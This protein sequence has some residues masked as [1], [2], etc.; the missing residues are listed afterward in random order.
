MLKK[1]I[2]ILIIAV[3]TTACG[4][5]ENFRAY[6][7]T[8][9]NAKERFRAGLNKVEKQPRTIDIN[10][11]VAVH[12]AP[13]PAG[14]DDFSDAINKGAKVL[15]HYPE[16]KWVD[17]A[18]LLIGKAYYYRH[19]F[20]A[21]LQ[22]FEELRNSPSSKMQQLSIIWKGRTLLALEKYNEGANYLEREL[23]SGLGQDVKRKPEI[24]VLAGEHHAMQKNWQQAAD[25]LSMAVRNIKNR[26]LLGRTLFLYGQVLE[27]LERYGEA[28]Y[29]FSRV[30]EH[31]P[32]FEYIY[33]AKVK[34][35]EVARKEGNMELAI[36]LYEDLSRDDKNMDRR[37]ELRF[38]I[39]RTLE[40]S[41]EID[42]AVT[43]YNDL[44]KSDQRLPAD[45]TSVIYFRLG[46]IYSDAFKNYA[47]AAAYFD[48]S[49]VLVTD[50]KQPEETEDAHTLAKALGKVTQL[51]NKI[52]R[53][54][55]LLWLSSL[56]PAKLDSVIKQ[57]TI[58]RKSQLLR[59]REAESANLLVNQ[60]IQ[61]KGEPT[62]SSIYGFLN[63]Q[64]EELVRRGKAEFRLLWGDRPLVDNWRRMEVVQQVMSNGFAGTNQQ[65]REEK[66]D[67]VLNIHL[68]EIPRTPEEQSALQFERAVAQYELGNLFFLN[69]DAP[70]SAAVYFR[71]VIK[72]TEYQ[73]LQ[74]KAMYSLYELYKSEQKEDRLQFWKKRIITQYPDSKFAQLIR[75]GTSSLK[76]D[77]NELLE[78]YQSIKDLQ[79][80]RKAPK[81]RRLALN[82]RST[83][84]AAAIFFQSVKE[85]IRRAKAFDRM[86]TFMLSVISGDSNSF[87]H[88][89]SMSF[90]S[91][92][93]DSVLIVLDE[94]Q[95][96]FPDGAHAEEV[97]K[98]KN[99]LTLHSANEVA[100]CKELG[101]ALK[102]KP[103]LEV[104]LQKVVYPDSLKNR[105][106][107]GFI[108]YSFLVT[109]SG[110]VE[111][112]R[113][114]TER[115]SLGIEEAFEAAFKHLHFEPPSLKNAAKIRC[116]FDFPVAR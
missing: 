12:Y 99:V 96:I 4:S 43:H 72:D 2:F 79:P 31:F 59:Q 89:G 51:Q 30:S 98:L 66:V 94:Y 35:A 48:S 84:P 105:S 50:Q 114:L 40:M 49:S 32:G 77:D 80:V 24:Q 115:S 14:M 109:K 86:D 16:S 73:D 20:Y 116:S 27:Q 104:F 39:A 7:N 17:D 10:Q 22:K 33:W 3:L 71:R 15:Q 108:T 106:L 54:D 85:Y 8:Y 21:A 81:L 100:T 83:E 25:W 55:S 23:S 111:S 75:S 13:A 46:K 11:P 90:K 93:W 113:L 36:H 18:V 87:V 19:E 29:T 28:Y 26:A 57:L 69:L 103:S 47:T 58:Q 37:D 92:H 68:D 9:Y 63:H 107:S 102:V 6:Y 60:S 101:I 64:N 88:T 44:L 91:V 53:A 1:S 112:Y 56:S 76:P 62:V 42:E 82:Y 65:V 110:E 5:W 45:L 97:A 61:R 34:Q 67:T 52:H 38:H 41:G 78:N 70:D 95:T 74:M